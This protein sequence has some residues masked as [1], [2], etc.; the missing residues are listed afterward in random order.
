MNDHHLSS[1]SRF[2]RWASIV[3][4]RP[5]IFIFAASIIAVWAISGPIFGFS[6]TWQLVINSFTTI[7]TFLMVFLIHFGVEHQDS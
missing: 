1:F 2:A 7:A 4:G 5:S 3:T 6:N